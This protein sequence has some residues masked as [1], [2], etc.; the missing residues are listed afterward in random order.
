ARAYSRP[1]SGSV[2]P[3]LSLIREPRPPPTIE[4]GRKA[5]SPVLLHWNAPACPSAQITSL[6]RTAAKRSWIGGNAEATVRQVPVAL[7]SRKSTVPSP[8]L[9]PG[10]PTIAR[11]PDTAKA[12]PCC[13]LRRPVESTTSLVIPVP[14][15][16]T[17]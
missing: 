10:I 3:Q 16:S 1:V 8:P 5:R 11:P 7:R 4:I 9:S 13:E 12:P 14:S 17:R 6:P 15:A 2:Q